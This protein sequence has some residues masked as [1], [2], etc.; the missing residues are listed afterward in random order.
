MV[1]TLSS[2]PVPEDGAGGFLSQAPAGSIRPFP[3]PS[4]HA[5][6]ARGG[7]ASPLLYGRPRR[8][9]HRLH[10]AR[11]PSGLFESDQIP[12]PLVAPDRRDGGQAKRGCKVQAPMGCQV[13]GSH[14]V[15]PTPSTW[16]A[17]RSGSYPPSAARRGKG[18][19][20]GGGKEARESA[21]RGRGN[22]REKRGWGKGMRGEPCD[23]RRARARKNGREDAQGKRTERGRSK[24]L[25]ARYQPPQC[26]LA[27]MLRLPPLCLLQ[28]STARARCHSHF[29]TFAKK[30]RPLG[31]PFQ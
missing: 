29:G 12:L 23:R 4:L 16:V 10:L 1:T 9:C 8:R 22:A 3:G 6:P 2:F 17:A 11:G 15:E 5:L 24:H 18:G 26:G 21:R 27:R 28:V 25:G 20:E 14:A 7:G 30:L 13:T 19:V 31:P